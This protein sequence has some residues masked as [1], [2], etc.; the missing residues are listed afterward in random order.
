MKAIIVDDE[1]RARDVLKKL[2]SEF[3]PDVEVMECCRDVPSA[4]IAINKHQPDV[5]FLDIE[6]PNY[7]GFELFSFFQEVNFQVIFA[8]AYSQYALKAFEVSAIDYL[9]KPIDIDKLEAAVQKVREFQG[10]KE[11][12]K[13]LDTLKTN[14]SAKKISRIALPISEGLTFIEIDDIIM[15]EADGAYTNIG[16]KNG[17]KMLISKKI[18]FF[19][20]V[21]SDH[22]QFYRV[23][24]SSIANIN[25]IEHY[26]RNESFLRMDNQA[27]VKIAR[28][29]KLAFEEY[30]TS[31]KL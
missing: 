12:S 11:L 8:T 29:K 14:M 7:S 23:H 13:R 16:L 20:E 5:V 31:Y 19:E 4:V 30:I 1:Q 15:L 2:I 27:I 3:C 21:L 24:R 9:L 28:N 6:M 10:K 22:T 17:K 26:S 25:C 18:K